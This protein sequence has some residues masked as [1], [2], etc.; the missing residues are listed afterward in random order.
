MS[1]RNGN[2]I[3]VLTTGPE[4]GYAIWHSRAMSLPIAVPAFDPYER[5]NVLPLFVG[6]A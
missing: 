5:D 2:T 4:T 3:E 1:I 6:G